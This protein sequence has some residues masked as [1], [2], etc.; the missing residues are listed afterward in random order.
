MSERADLESEEGFGQPLEY[1]DVEEQENPPPQ[2]PTAFW[3]VE[4]ESVPVPDAPTPEEDSAFDDIYKNIRP[5]YEDQPYIPETSFGDFDPVPIGE[6]YYGQGNTGGETTPVEHPYPEGDGGNNGGLRPF[7]II[8][9]S[10]T[11]VQVNTG[12]AHWKGEWETPTWDA[13]GFNE[14]KVISATSTLQLKCDIAVEGVDVTVD[15]L[16]IGWDLTAT[17]QGL[18]AR[19]YEIDFISETVT[20]YGTDAEVVIDIAVVTFT[21]GAISSIDQILDYNPVLPWNRDIDTTAD[22]GGTGVPPP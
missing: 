14:D 20:E 22:G 11:V 9:V 2:E 1:N 13:G 10:D 7:Q 16:N 8:Q 4:E 6:N 5:S 19:N 21:D 3:E 18:P 17:Y 12:R 15:A